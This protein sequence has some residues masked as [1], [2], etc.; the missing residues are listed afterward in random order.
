LYRM[1]AEYAA[2]Q[3]QPADQDD[4][5]HTRWMRETSNGR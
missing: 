5:V 3:K 2:N 1:E 4:P